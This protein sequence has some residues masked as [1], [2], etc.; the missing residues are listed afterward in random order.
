M[1]LFWRVWLLRT[2]VATEA[3]A[4]RLARIAVD[5]AYASCAYIQRV[6]SL[7]WWQGVRHDEEE[8]V[9]EARVRQQRVRNLERRWRANHPY[10]LPLFERVPAFVNGDYARWMRRGE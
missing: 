2:T 10:E 8:F 6:R 9:V 3:D 7:Y 4:D 1:G 5:E